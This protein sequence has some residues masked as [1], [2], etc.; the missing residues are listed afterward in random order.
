LNILQVIPEL[1][2]G[3][4]ERTTIEV[5]EAIVAD[6]GRALVASR[7]GRLEDELEAV[8][9]ELLRLDAKTKNPLTIW[10]NAG[11]LAQAVKAEQID[12]IHA[13]SR[14]PAWSAKWAAKRTGAAFR[15]DLSRHLFGALALE[16]AL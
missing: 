5:A 1:D 7:G 11:R 3:G 2:A 13:R 6:G 4:A 10:S 9:G 16:A 8:G 14:A 15:D 12:L